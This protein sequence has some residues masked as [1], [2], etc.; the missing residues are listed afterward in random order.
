MVLGLG[1]ADETVF[2]VTGTSG[3]SSSNYSLTGVARLKGADKNLPTN[4]AVNC[5]NVEDFFNQYETV[6]GGLTDMY[7]STGLELTEIATP[8]NPAA[9]KNKLYTK[10]DDGFY[11]LNSA[12]TEVRLQDATKV[13]TTTDD[14]TAV[15]DVTI[16][17]Q[18]QLTAIANATT[19]S[20]TGTGVAGQKLIIRL[21]DAGVAKA[22]T[23]DG[24]FRAVGT[25]LPTTTVVS[26]T[27]YIGCIYN[28]TD[29]K[30]DAVAVVVQA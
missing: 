11:R 25:T 22:L 21:K 19:I 29:T 1:T 26:K 20:T 17:D 9:G 13:V 24:I 7:D 8:S 30:W 3:T 14:A 23:W 5:I 6:V 4:T 2:T 16:T 27:H 18:Y 15:I 10:S 28:A 12:G